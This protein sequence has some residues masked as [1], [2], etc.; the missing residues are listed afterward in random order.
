M[1]NADAGGRTTRVAMAAWLVVATAAGPAVLAISGC[2]HPSYGE[3]LLCSTD[4][5]CPDGWSCSKPA[6]V[7]TPDGIA[8]GVDGG[9]DSGV[10]GTPDGS[11]D[12][13]A[14][15]CFGTAP[16]TICLT[17]RPAMPR[18]L[19]GTIDTLKS[20]L[21]DASTTAG[22]NYCVIIATTIVV[23]GKL[24]AIGSRP[25]VL[26]A[27]DTITVND[28]IDVGSGVLDSNPGAGSPSSACATG[29]SPG[30]RGGGAG[31]SF[32]GAGGAGGKGSTVSNTDVGGAGGKPGTAVKGTI[33]MIRGGCP[34][35]SG[36]ANSFAAGRGGGAVYLI[37]GTSIDIGRNGSILAAG[38]GGTS[39]DPRE[40]G[41]GGG[42]GGMIGLDAPMVTCSSC[43]VILANGGGG[44]EGG[45]STNSGFPG[46]DSIDIL[47]AVG[48]AGSADLGWDGGDGSAGLSG[49]TGASGL[50]GTVDM[51]GGAGAGGGG[52]GGAGLIL[53]PAS[54]NL[55]TQVS[56]LPVPL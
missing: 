18:N 27:S 53:A 20:A 25:L 23:N 6:N 7:C 43:G 17:Q 48:G 26:I 34:G 8:G 21:C 56:P 4:G 15:R 1:R 3:G 44:G 5:A 41:D 28:T 31:G 32:A 9:V 22:S 49:G 50:P 35:Q 14:S 55:G 33:T 29:A 37:A 52:G 38:E 12:A 51:G 47:A 11:V 36:N 45:G 13:P 42:S 24:R 46:G 54:A 2:F 40:G 30:T 16:F 39:G 19:S 10:H